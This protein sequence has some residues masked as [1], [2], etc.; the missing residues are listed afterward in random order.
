MGLEAF[1][2]GAV[3]G[4]FVESSPVAHRLLMRNLAACGF[5]GRA[6]VLVDD[7]FAALKKIGKSGEPFDLIFADPPFKESLRSRIVLAVAE[8][9]VLKTGGVL[10]VEHDR[11]D[12]DPT[13]CEPAA[14][15]QKRFGDCTVS[16][17][18]RGVYH[19]DRGVSRDV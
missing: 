5:S 9:A 2:R 3:E 14:F 17:Y 11:R 1:S 12:A 15:Q 18:G 16:F 6:T 13:P 8:T 10:V 7:V 19:E 4:V